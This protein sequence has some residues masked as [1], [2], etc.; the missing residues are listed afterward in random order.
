M[1]A[2]VVHQYPYGRLQLFSRH[3]IVKREELIALI[4]PEGAGVKLETTGDCFQTVAAFISANQVSRH[5]TLRYIEGPFKGMTLEK[6]RM[7]EKSIAD[8]FAST[9]SH[10]PA[11]RA[12]V[13][14][15][16]GYVWDPPLYATI[17]QSGEIVADSGAVHTSLRG[18]F[19]DNGVPANYVMRTIETLMHGFACNVLLYFNRCSFTRTDH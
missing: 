12:L 17:T 18:F 13:H 4:L 9:S 11:G 3:N 10:R 16:S 2:T 1:P 6:A 14:N 7:E 8:Q 15:R 5:H 19:S